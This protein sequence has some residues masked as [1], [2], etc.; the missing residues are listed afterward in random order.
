MLITGRTLFAFV[1]LKDPFMPSEIAGEDQPGPILSL[2]AARQFDFLFLFHT[3]HTRTN[4]TATHEEV[5]RRYEKCHVMIHELPVSDP[6]DYSGLMGRLAREV[7]QIMRLSRNAEN[8]VCVSSGTAEMRAAW[9]LLTAA[10][11][12]PATLLQVAS[13]ADPLFGAANVKEVHLDTGDWASLRDLVMPQ[14]YFL[15]A[16]AA[17]HSVEVTRDRALHDA[18]ALAAIAERISALMDQLPCNVPA[19]PR[20]SSQKRPCGGAPPVE[21]RPAAISRLPSKPHDT[22]SE[23]AAMSPSVAPP[24]E[25]KIPTPAKVEA[26][27]REAT[28][29]ADLR[30]ECIRVLQEA[31][32]LVDQAQARAREDA[33]AVAAWTESAPPAMRFAMRLEHPERPLQPGL[34]DALQELGICTCSAVMRHVV[35]S[36]ALAAESDLPVLLLG[37]TG[38]GKELTA[39][40]IHRMSSRRDRE[41]VTVNCAGIPRD[42]AE[43]LL[44]GHVKGSFTG[45]NKDQ[46]GKFEHANKSTLFLDELAELSLEVQGKL[47]RVIEDFKV[48]PLGSNIPRKVEVRI[49]AATN[50]DLQ[51]AVA[52]GRFR[53]DLYHRLSFFPIK[54]PPLRERQGEIPRLAV[55]LLRRINQRRS[56]EKQL[57]T[58]AVRRLEQH[59]WP[60]NVRE[61]VSVLERSVLYCHT[62]VLGPDDL[63]IEESVPRDPFHG[64]PE[65]HPGFSLEAFLSQMRAK[66]I[67]RAL[68]K[69]GNNQSAAADLLGVSKQAINTY[70]RNQAGN[71]N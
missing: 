60:G 19:L 37:E 20:P 30:Q 1:D 24:E 6:K 17:R 9:F 38:T 58:D 21:Q 8:S 43:S 16:R 67:D 12:L 36:A 50:H 57:S 29:V 18:R 23:Q 42:L 15:A 62:D 56:R 5:R 32:S 33:E 13:P 34:E 51:K 28:R 2:M 40:L 31:R 52:E 35:E 4:A 22:A 54:L 45:A 48:E 7:R 71:S 10:G 70:V 65:P 26:G 55:T 25:A 49:V 53:S 46:T 27:H 3:P 61:L 66:L 39:K 68:E 47:L 63:K 64:L 14:E 44:F 69:S 11:A 41:M 59:D